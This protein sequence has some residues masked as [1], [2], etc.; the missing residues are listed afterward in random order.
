MKK[1]KRLFAVLFCMALVL[2]MLQLVPAEQAKADDGYTLYIGF[3]AD[4]A[5]SGDWGCQYNSPNAAD[6]KGEVTAVNETIAVGET[7]TVSVTVPT[8][9]LHTYWIAPVLVAEGVTELDAT[10][11]LKVDGADVEIDTAAGDAW[12]YE[13]TGEYSAE[14]SI[15]LAG[16]YNE[17]GTQYIASPAFT[18]VEYTV[19]LNRIVMGGAEQAPEEEKND[20][21]PAA[22]IPDTDS[23]VLYVGFGGDASESGDWGYQYNSPNAADNKGEV[24]AVTETIAVGETRTVSVTVPSAVLHTYWIAP[25]LNAEG[26]V[27]LDATVSL[28]VDGADVP[29]DLTAGDAWWYEGTGEYSAEQAIRLAGG[30][31]E[32]G[33][34]YVASPAFTTLEYTVTL[35]ALAKADPDAAPGG[36]EPAVPALKA[37]LDGTYNAYLGFQT[38]TYSFRNAFDDAT[39]GR[40]SEHFDKICGWDPDNNL[41]YR[42]GTMTDVEI[43]GNGTY[44]VSAEGLDLSGDFDSQETFNLLF[45]STDIPNSG[46]IVISDIVVK[47]NGSEVDDVNPI[48]SPDSPEYLNM[49]IVNQWNKD[50]E[51]IGYYAVPP[52]K[53]AITFTVSGM[54]YDKPADPTPEPTATS[55]PEPTTAPEPTKEETKNETPA[56]TVTDAPVSG[57]STDDGGSNTGL[58]VG[59]VIAVVVVAAGVVAVVMKKKKN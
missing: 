4:A 23:H 50:I 10:V 47:V 37:D 6:N 59:I 46:E 51:P 29:I 7:K 16:G 53:L 44:T 56:P 12:W 32:W 22:T 48:V 35:N 17:W 31:N 28:K 55:A 20:D 18:T 52:T 11:A 27:E 19:T 54:N 49:L 33:A 42:D 14:Q 1:G 41:I 24:T 38:P 43:K 34:Q 25:V 13:G 26:I 9:V 5:E 30:Y 39:Y 57:S 21:A 40:D 2:N 15:R 8:A 36:D 45:L 3:G 58:I